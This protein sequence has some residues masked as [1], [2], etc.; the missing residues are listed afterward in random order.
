MD[1]PLPDEYLQ[2]EPKS[3]SRR[4]RGPTVNRLFSTAGPFGGNDLVSLFGSK[5][6]GLVGAGGHD[7]QGTVATGGVADS[8]SSDD[9]LRKAADPSTGIISKTSKKGKAA[10]TD[11][12]PLGV[13]M[14]INF[15]SVG[16][17]DNYVNQLK[18]MVSLPLMYPEVY[19]KF[20]ITPP[21]G[22]LFHGPPGTGKTLMA[23]ALASSFSTENRKVT[24]FMR[25]GADC[26]SKWVGEAE[27]QLRLLFE[28]AKNKQPS[29]IFFDE[30]DGLAPVRSS[31]QEQIHASIVSTLLA[32][33]DGMDNRGQV[34]VIGATNR[35]D[36]VDPALRRP[37]RFDREFYFPLPE[38]EARKEIIAIHTKKWDPPLEP[39]FIE[40]IAK[41]TKGYG[42]ADLRALCTEAALGAIQRRYPQIYQSSKKLLIDTNSINVSGKDFLAAV[43]KIVPSSARST[44]SIASPLPPLVEPLLSKV[45][46]SIKKKLDRM[47]PQKKKTNYLEKALYEDPIEDGDT[48]LA[49]ARQEAIKEFQSSRI[50]RPRLLV[51]GKIG[52]GQQYLGSA[53]LHHLEGFHVQSFDLGTIFSNPATTPEATIVQLLVEVRRHKPSVIFIPNIDVWFST[54][55]HSALSTFTGFLR[56]IG[57]NEPILLLG[58]IESDDLDEIDPFIQDMFGYSSENIQTIPATTTKS[59]EEFFATLIKFVC[60]K[61]TDFPQEKVKRVLEELPEAPPEE[62]KELSKEDAKLIAKKDLGLINTIKIKLNSLMEPL[63]NRYKK[64]RK[65]VIDE[66]YL[67]HLLNPAVA[68]V[69]TAPAA[70]TITDDD[71]ILEVATGKKYY[72]MDLDVIEERLWNGHYLEPKQFLKDIKMIHHD[73]VETGDRERILKASEML[74]NVEVYIDELYKDSQFIQDC[75]DMHKRKK[76]QLKKELEEREALE[77]Q[78]KEAEEAPEGTLTQTNMLLTDGTEIAAPVASETLNEE[79]TQVDQNVDLEMAD[80]KETPAT[81]TETVVV[82]TVKQETILTNGSTT[83]HVTKEQTT[84]GTVQ[85][86]KDETLVE[87]EPKQ[88][89]VMEPVPEEPKAV[90]P[91]TVAVEKVPEEPVEEPHEP[92]NLSED[93]LNA[94]I[95]TLIE[96]TDGLSIERLE[97][98][99]SALTDV[100][101]SKRFE[102]NRDSIIKHLN[103]R[104]NFVLKNIKKHEEKQ[105]KQ[106]GQ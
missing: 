9:D 82:K 43:E 23:R 22:V 48:S 37:G 56:G 89:V 94:F 101:W 69:M 53:I 45:L 90:T 60:S 8:D 16:G 76:A 86:P 57:P 92:F 5:P 99:N 7:A 54:M 36:S 49:F 19:Q 6:K 79:T 27:R 24:F 105:L 51:Q 17:L 77:K 87:E 28:E 29:I 96:S 63:R 15:S 61:P 68:S 58:L 70:Y 62:E 67:L 102:W 74:T 25:K 46:E 80:V 14:N 85:V 98:L 55:T 78:A 97:Q 75:S 10:L 38:F 72:N 95:S 91:E 59:R 103:K 26:L 13:D 73:C 39:A 71:M 66:Q 93:K 4:T 104:L 50:F 84:N 20:G 88:D 3:S 106:I 64:F 81:A 83:V 52:M 65:P 30:I 18:E 11:S 41:V 1:E 100:V 47:V 35:P 32:L 42:G 31:K 2:T 44:L 12:D 33:M 40:H 21:R 34:V